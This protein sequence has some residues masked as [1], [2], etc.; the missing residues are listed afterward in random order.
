[1]FMS[2]HARCS[3]SSGLSLNYKLS[4]PSHAKN[5]VSIMTTNHGKG[6]QHK[7]VFTQYVHYFYP[8]LTN[9]GMYQQI[10]VKSS[11][12]WKHEKPS[13]GSRHVPRG[14]ADLA[15]QIENLRH[16]RVMVPRP[17]RL[18]GVC[19][20]RQ[21]NLYRC[22]WPNCATLIDAKHCWKLGC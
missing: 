22:V 17:R 11:Q 20:W 1:M 5:V 12:I 2:Y 18:S 6:S 16:T 10:L 7:Q 8:I 14:R 9:D 3:T 21:E 4:F 15:I 13:G 19:I